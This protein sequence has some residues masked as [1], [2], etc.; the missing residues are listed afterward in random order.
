M[1]NNNPY[2]IVGIGEV[3]WDVLPDETKL[4]GAPANFAYHAGALGDAAYIF[5][6]V[7]KDESGSKLTAQLINLNMNTDYIQLDDVHPTGTVHVKLDASGQPSYH[8]APDAAWDYIAWSDECDELAS[9]ADAVCWG[10]LAQRSSVSRSTIERFI[11]LMCSDSWRIFD[12]NLRQDFYSVETIDASL[13][14]ANVVKLNDEELPRVVHLLKSQN[15]I[16]PDI[17]RVAAKGDTEMDDEET[18][19]RWLLEAYD[20]RLVCVTRGGR[21][22]L[23]ITAREAYTHAGCAVQVVDTIGAGDAFTATM[24][25]HLLRGSS[26]AQLSAAANKVGAYVASQ[27]GAMPPMPDAD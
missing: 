7:G 1:S 17:N 25:H 24:A 10:T 26:L 21:G 4:G 9:R 18:G 27:R 22:S 14:L 11:S 6:R 2:V 16:L 20:L 15:R 19:A 3:L 8:I 13:R 12:A 5:S 23:I